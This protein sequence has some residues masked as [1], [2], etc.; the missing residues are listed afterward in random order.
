[1]GAGLPRCAADD[2]TVPHGYDT[3]GGDRGSLDPSFCLLTFSLVNPHRLPVSTTFETLPPRRPLAT[4][5]SWRKF[6]SHH[7][8]LLKRVRMRG[9]LV[10][11]L[12]LAFSLQRLLGKYLL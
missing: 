7:H 10:T 8:A 1:M 3:T 11:M 12:Q 9:I 4:P 5:P 6:V 2:D